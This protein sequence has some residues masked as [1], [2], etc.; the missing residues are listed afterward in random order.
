MK[1]KN[2]IT[3]YQ[4]KSESR[5]IKKNEKIMK[6][7]IDK[8]LEYLSTLT[9]DEADFIEHVLKWSD[10]EKMAF[11]IAKRIFDEEIKNPSEE[12]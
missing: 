9:K 7:S 6:D 1:K 5:Y 4:T 3:I 12:G 2:D 8:F 11:M 10:Q